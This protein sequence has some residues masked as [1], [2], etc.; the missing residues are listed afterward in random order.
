M[1]NTKEDAKRFLRWRGGT[2]SRC[3]PRIVESPASKL[4]LAT[5]ES[6][7]QTGSGR[8]ESHYLYQRTLITL[9]FVLFGFCLTCNAK[10]MPI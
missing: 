2:W 1:D 8:P 9:Q 7:A 10:L 4:S 6:I 5:M 3:R